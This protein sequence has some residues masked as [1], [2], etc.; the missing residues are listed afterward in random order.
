VIIEI[1]L[2]LGNKG[3]VATAAAVIV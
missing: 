2:Y 3:L 1:V